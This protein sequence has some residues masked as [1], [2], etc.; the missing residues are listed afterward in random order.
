[1]NG[2]FYF[3]HNIVTKSMFMI[4]VCRNLVFRRNVVV[5]SSKC[6][7]D[8]THYDFTFDLDRDVLYFNNLQRKIIRKF[9][10]SKL[11]VRKKWLH[12]I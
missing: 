4:L 3:R 7:H 6:N 2:F 9:N 5:K 10:S 1:M 8:N 11:R 12:N